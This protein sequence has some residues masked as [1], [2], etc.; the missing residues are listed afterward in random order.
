MPRKAGLIIGGIFGLLVG[1]LF[2]SVSRAAGMDAMPTRVIVGAVVAGFFGGVMGGVA[3]QMTRDARSSGLGP[4]IFTA[5][6]TGA[7]G[8][9][10]WTFFADWLGLRELFRL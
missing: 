6:I 7:F 2:G 1:I 4:A 8:A 9:W 5:V 10:Q 3:G